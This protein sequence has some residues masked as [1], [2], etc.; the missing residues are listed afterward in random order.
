LSYF[1]SAQGHETLQK[2][3]ILQTKSFETLKSFTTLHVH[4]SKS[5][6]S[7]SDASSAPNVMDNATFTESDASVI[8]MRSRLLHILESLPPSIEPFK[9]SSEN[10]MD[11]LI[12]FLSREITAIN[13]LLHVINS[14]LHRLNDACGERIAFTKDIRR[15]RT[16]IESYSS[17]PKGW[18]AA[19]EYKIPGDI[20]FSD[21]LQDFCFRLAHLA[22]LSKGT[23]RKS[24]A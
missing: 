17:P 15:L 7:L 12:R 6:R 22:R 23:L 19:A 18:I 13:N 24:I 20:N 2:W 5:S 1:S 3:R 4:K 11:P 9:Q 8:K 14:S 16:E 21:W 10:L